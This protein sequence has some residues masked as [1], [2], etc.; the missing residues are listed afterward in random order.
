MEP[1]V[2]RSWHIQNMMQ[3]R[4]MNQR[5]RMH[6]TPRIN[7][8]KISNPINPTNLWS[9]MDLIQ[10]H[11][12][13]IQLDIVSINPRMNQEHTSNNRNNSNSMNKKTQHLNSIHTF[14]TPSHRNNKNHPLNPIITSPNP[15]PIMDQV[16]GIWVRVRMKWGN[17]RSHLIIW[18]MNWVCFN[19][20]LLGLS[21][22]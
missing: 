16:V 6:L 3:M 18:K 5:V 11:F 20:K 7:L 22:S 2:H 13:I 14:P 1:S 9:Q 4:I 10:N 19:K 21:Q 8:D 15:N 12:N 17:L